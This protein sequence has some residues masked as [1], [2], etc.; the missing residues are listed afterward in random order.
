MKEYERNR[1]RDATKVDINRIP[2]WMT[3]PVSGFESCVKPSSN[4]Q[5]PLTTTRHHRRRRDGFLLFI[6]KN[7]I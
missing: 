4:A 3:K 7:G 5:L 2:Y 6:K 1:N